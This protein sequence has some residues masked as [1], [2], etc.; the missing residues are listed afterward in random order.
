MLTAV[1][2]DDRHAWGSAAVG[3][4][5]IGHDACAS[6]VCSTWVSNSLQFRFGLESRLSEF[7]HGII[8]RPLRFRF[9][10]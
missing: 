6:A 3:S 5:S 10:F 9:G 8:S 7:Q 1:V 2:V 4:V